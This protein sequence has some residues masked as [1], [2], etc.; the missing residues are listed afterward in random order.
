MSSGLYPVD[1][2]RCAG[3][4]SCLAYFGGASSVRGALD[5]GLVHPPGT[6]WD[7]ENYDISGAV[8]FGI[9]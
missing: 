8:Q 1:N 5:R 6:Q 2:R 3:V 7:Y 9:S 4:G